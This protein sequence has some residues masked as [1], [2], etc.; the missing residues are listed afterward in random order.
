MHA[1]KVHG[2]VH[3]KP[4][5]S[6]K[7]MKKSLN[8]KESQVNFTLPVKATNV[9][10]RHDHRK[11]H[12]I[13]TKNQHSL[14]RY[15][16][17]QESMPLH[18]MATISNDVK[19]RPHPSKDVQAIIDEI[20]TKGNKILLDI[21][22][23]VSRHATGSRLMDLL[24]KAR[25]HIEQQVPG[26]DAHVRV[27][28]VFGMCREDMELKYRSRETIAL[29]MTATRISDESQIDI[30]LRMDAYVALGFCLL[31]SKRRAQDAEKALRKASSL[32]E[33]TGGLF[34]TERLLHG[35][36]IKSIILQNRIPTAM[37]MSFAWVQKL[38]EEGNQAEQ[39]LS[40][41]IALYGLC[42][43]CEKGRSV[44]VFN[45]WCIWSNEVRVGVAAY[46]RN[47]CRGE[48]F[49]FVA[50]KKVL[51]AIL[52]LVDELWWSKDLSVCSRS[53]RGGLML[54][55]REVARRCKDFRRANYYGRQFVDQCKTYGTPMGVVQAYIRL[56]VGYE[57]AGR[58]DRA[59]ETFDYS[60]RVGQKH[61]LLEDHCDAIRRRALWLHRIGKT[62][63][64]ITDLYSAKHELG[65]STKKCMFSSSASIHPNDQP[66]LA[67]DVSDFFKC[68]GAVL[69]ALGVVL[70]DDGQHQKAKQYLEKSLL[71]S[72]YLSVKWAL[73][74]QH[75][76]AIARAA[77]Y[78]RQED[79]DMD[80]LLSED[81]LV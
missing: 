10:A 58:N 22:A 67:D 29:F 8:A 37:K 78:R 69:C 76:D 57:M 50:N 47:L 41:A 31:C 74:R 77:Q 66:G 59:R 21:A 27:Y 5:E 46:V 32:C 55:A 62:E 1:D 40:R 38:S 25:K 70:Y 56:A 35:L 48:G 42:V 36:T 49:L 64:A 79:D 51:M 3:E 54:G 60:V 18:S 81:S 17:L 19:I 68:Y 12:Q 73:A 7:V 45:G 6:K 16:V 20:C 15:G 4:N 43:K 80:D 30:H 71:Y 52:D 9:V 39:Y 65:K 72:P 63:R 26:T 2:V 13:S 34:Y 24:N 61:Q 53:L 11:L 33:R 28:L 75:I 44:P 23:A 14:G